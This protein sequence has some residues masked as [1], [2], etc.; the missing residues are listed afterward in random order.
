MVLLLVC[1]VI[2]V[3]VICFRIK[4]PSWYIVTL[5]TGDRLLLPGWNSDNVELSPSRPLFNGADIRTILEF[6]EL[7]LNNLH[8]CRFLFF[9]KKAGLGKLQDLRSLL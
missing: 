3:A 5:A 2:T 9:R 4:V 8:N 1:I 6:F 7:F